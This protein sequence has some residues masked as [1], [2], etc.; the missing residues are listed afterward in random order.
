[1]SFKGWPEITMNSNDGKSVK[2]KTPLIISASR[3]TDIPAFYSEWLLNQLK[4]GYTTWKNPFNG[5]LS[6][7]SFRNTR[8][9][10]FWSKNPKPI[11]PYLDTLDEMNLRYYF[12]F[13]LNDYAKEGLEPNVPP[14]SERIE[15]FIK[16]SE[17]IGKE[18][19]IWRFDPL[20][21]TD[22]TGT[23]ELLEKI[24]TIGSQIS[25]YTCKLVFSFIQIS[26]YK[27]VQ[28]K[29]MKET[30]NF[31][32]KDVKNYEFTDEQK[33][34]FANQLYN[35]AKNWNIEL[36]SCAEPTDL[37]SYNIKH[38]KCIDDKLIRKL[39]M[40]D[41]FL[42]N[43]LNTGKIKKQHNIFHNNIPVNPHLKD[44]GQRKDCGCIYSKD[45]G[46]YNTCPHLCAYCYA[47]SDS[48]SILDNYGQ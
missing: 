36:A 12:H 15:T 38:N 35:I 42:M 41:T 48:K 33:H 43:F 3:A 4:E 31:S 16:L 10:V 24:R 46:K 26:P 14:L 6:Y 30:S 21:K 1:M 25:P 45:I 11:L 13:T 32:Q 29:L 8:V 37:S 9:I 23:P 17:K 40:H 34:C 27:K 28:R 2:A 39:F 20:V 19:V 47:N 18:K 22:E 7:I 5:K 44:K